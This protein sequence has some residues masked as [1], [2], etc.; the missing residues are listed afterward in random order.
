MSVLDFNTDDKEGTDISL[1]VGSH[2]VR[3]TD[4]DER[5]KEALLSF[6]RG[7][8]QY[9]L[10]RLP[11]G[12]YRRV[13][14]RVF[15]GV[16][17]KRTFFHFHRHQ[18]DD[19][20]LHL[21][22]Y[23]IPKHRIYVDYIDVPKGETVEFKVID[24]RTPRDNQEKFIKYI[25]NKQ[26]SNII[27]LDPG[28]GKTFITLIAIAILKVRT[29]FIIKPMYV[30][31]WIGDIHEAY[32]IKVKDIMVVRGGK[33]M[34]AFTQLAEYNLVES[35]II[36]VSSMTYLNYLKDYETFGEEVIEIGYGCPPHTLME[37]AGVG[38]VIVDEVH[39]NPHF[40]YR[41][42]AYTNVNKFLG[43]SGSFES[44]DPFINKIYN[45]LFP[46]YLRVDNGERDIYVMAKAL[47]YRFDRNKV[48][49]HT[50]FARKSYSHIIYEQSIMKQQHR[51]VNYLKMIES[52]T[53]QSFVDIREAGQKMIIYC[54]T[55]DMCT[56]VSEYLKPR[57]PEL[58]VQRYTSDDDYEEMIKSDLIVS[59]IK[60]LGT[61][62]DVPGLRIILL[63]DAINSSQANIQVIGRLRRLKDWPDVTPEF[64]YL[65]NL[66]IPKHC[67]YHQN[68]IDIFKPRVLA[69]KV[70]TT[71]FKV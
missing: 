68:K 42:N 40:N 23:G 71:Q 70:I 3:I 33:D 35:K 49:R 38:F 54:A 47:E 24:K 13:M 37:K 34:K 25:C 36:I 26:Q 14:T 17:K 58:L 69:H 43:L 52:I 16:D 51:L 57:Y 11:G 30:E 53:K 61:A 21:G 46:P 19:I 67:E 56:K 9:T 2:Y 32:N 5:G 60:S 1:E 18:L 63:T 27:T 55:V 15:V 66:D 62:I 22:S 8:A 39:E 44:D 50:N 28:S 64:L 59:T 48:I 65:V 4:F 7:M 20:I 29:C 41:A 12:R 31:K 45:L 10:E 6:C